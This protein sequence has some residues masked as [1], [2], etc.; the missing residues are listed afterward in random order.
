M[1]DMNFSLATLKVG[2]TTLQKIINELFLWF[3]IQNNV[4]CA[5]ISATCI[6][7]VFDK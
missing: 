2:R 3:R 1:I 4:S 6:K 7:L 5:M